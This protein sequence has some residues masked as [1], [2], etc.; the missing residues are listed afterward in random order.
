MVD[1]KNPFWKKYSLLDYCFK[2]MEAAATRVAFQ[3]KMGITYF[4]FGWDNVN[5]FTVHQIMDQMNKPALIKTLK[6]DFE[7]LCL[8]ICQL[9]APDCFTHHPLQQIICVLNW[10]NVLRF[11]FSKIKKL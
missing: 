8:K 2:E 9:K 6:K 4:D 5:Q 11:T 7:L 10:E 3:T 1:G